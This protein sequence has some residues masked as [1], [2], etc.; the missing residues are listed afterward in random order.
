MSAA[1]TEAQELRPATETVAVPPQ[2]RAQGTGSIQTALSR[3]FAAQAL[4]GLSL[5]CLAIYAVTAWSFQVKQASEFE[6][7]SELIKHLIQESRDDPGRDGLRHKLDD[8]FS[9][10]AEISLVLRR[11]DEIV[12]SSTPARTSGRWIWMPM[13]EQAMPSGDAAMQL[14]LGIDV[15]EDAKILARLAWTLVGAVVL[16]SAVISLTGALL[17]RRGCSH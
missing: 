15:R 1:K 9:T 17:V 4:I 3:W 2:R 14:Q 16:G 10:H 7:Q 5:V 8:F 12:Y 13:Q 6:R 11:D